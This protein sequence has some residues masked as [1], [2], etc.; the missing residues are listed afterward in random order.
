[1]Y[2]RYTLPKSASSPPEVYNMYGTALDTA[3]EFAVPVH[4]I[5]HP[6]ILGIVLSAMVSHHTSRPG[7]PPD[8]LAR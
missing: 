6:R 7:D 1:M 5:T 4:R 2:Y 8:L 3:K